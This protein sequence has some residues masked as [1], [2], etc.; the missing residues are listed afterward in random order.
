M[1]G[2]AGVVDMLLAAGADA[3]L[4]V[5]SSARLAGWRRWCC[6]I[7]HTSQLHVYEW[8]VGLRFRNVQPW[9]LAV[10]FLL[11]CRM[12]LVAARCWRPASMGMTTWWRC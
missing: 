3:N 10:P 6:R 7:V 9:L 5:C 12:R 4:Q 11:A 8:N 2:H 1:K